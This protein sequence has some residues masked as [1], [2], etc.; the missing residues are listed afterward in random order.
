MFWPAPAA[1]T[2]HIELY[3][4]GG[5]RATQSMIPGPARRHGKPGAMEA[6]RPASV[7]GGSC[8]RTGQAV[9]INNKIQNIASPA[10]SPAVGHR[11]TPYG[12]AA[13]WRSHSAAT[14]GFGGPVPGSRDNQGTITELMP[15]CSRPLPKH[16][17]RGDAEKGGLKPPPP[18]PKQQK[19]ISFAGC[20]HPLQASP[21]QTQI[22]P[23]CQEPEE[24]TN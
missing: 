3:S 13:A 9:G 24:P 20:P 8:G 21:R 14:S 7:R 17:G 1:R 10:L 23:W 11:A 16:P 15:G 12:P 4:G 19:R 2:Q 18:L 22:R 6:S 5:R